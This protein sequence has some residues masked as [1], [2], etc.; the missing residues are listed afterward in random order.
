VTR[1]DQSIQSPTGAN[2]PVTVELRVL[3]T[4][5]IHGHILPFDYLTQ[6]RDERAGLARTATLIQNARQQTR[7]CMLFDT[8]DFLQGTPL[9]DAKL[10]TGTRPPALHPAIGAMNTLGYDAVGLGNHEFNF[11]LD[12]LFESLEQAKFPVTCAN[13]A[14]VLGATV[15]E[16]STLFPQYLLLD[17]VFKD[18]L[19][20]SREIRVGVIGLLP[21]QIVD[22]DHFHLEGRVFSR[23]IVETACALVPRLRAEGADIVIALA[24]TGIARD[25]VQD[26]L[27]NAALSL[28]EVSGVDAI[29]AGHS[30]LVFP[31]AD[32]AGIDGVDLE[33]GRLHG[34][35]AVMAGAR[36]S[37]L[38]VLDL[39]LQHIGGKW[40]ITASK[41]D[42]RPVDRGRHSP[43]PE[44]DTVISRLLQHAHDATL[45]EMEKPVGH[46][47]DA[48]HSYLCMVRSDPLVH[49]VAQAQRSA[50]PRAVPK[51]VLDSFPI[52]SAASAFRSGGRAG[53]EFFTDIPA[54]PLTRRHA[55]DIYAFPNTL[56]ALILTGAQLHDW[57]ERAAGFFN[58]IT[59]GQADQVLLDPDF[60]GH[61]FDV[62][63]GLSYEIDLS[64]PSRYRPDGTPTQS[65]EPRVVNLR[66]AGQAIDLSMEFIVAT[67]NFRLFGGAPY[68]QGNVASRLFKSHFPV[69][70]ALNRHLQDIDESAKSGPT[71]SFCPMPGTSVVFETGPGLRRYPEE[72]AS[73]ALTDL[74]DT[75]KGFAKFRMQL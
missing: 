18:T 2:L 49:L 39:T 5:D 45:D 10:K 33:R 11:G 26:T 72:I 41:S 20:Q 29:L 34:V 22:W 59:P 56:C 53:P 66:H 73:L 67:N 28:A 36:G 51:H 69:I 55:S 13:A 40:K 44:A 48:L 19:G 63:D 65:R 17:R 52:L 30:H 62:I 68:S 71:W 58:Q 35:P 15:E 32:H 6:R 1:I 70:D 50:L 16:D 31:A 42:A 8:G 43:P 24:H 37:H 7:N 60:P 61:H 64:K 54:G 75:A 46:S 9:I 14:S 74:G 21:P 27:E 25:G 47:N 4:T 38:G 3:E 12:W 57:L 23:P